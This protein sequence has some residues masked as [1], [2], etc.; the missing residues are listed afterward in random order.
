MSAFVVEDRTIN[1]IVW[2]LECDNPSNP[3]TYGSTARLLAEAGYEMC[4]EHTPR[5]LAQDMHAMNVDAVCQR[6]ENERADRYN[7][8]YSR[9]V[10][11][12]THIQALKSL[13]CFL[14]QC[15]EGDVP[16]RPLFKVLDRIAQV[17]ASG[18]IHTLPEYEAAEWG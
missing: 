8:T 15:S 18:I 4:D 1:R 16:E 2:Y 17:I 9:Q 11:W 3:I 14:Y 10:G 12:P 6:Y 13:R 5:K 7:F